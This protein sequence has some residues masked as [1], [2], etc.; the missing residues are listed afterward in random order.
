M[1][2]AVPARGRMSPTTED[3]GNVMN[4]NSALGSAFVTRNVLSSVALL[5]FSG[6][7]AAGAQG[8]VT[9]SANTD[10]FSIVGTLLVSANGKGK[11]DFT[12]IVHR[13]SVDGTTVAAVCQYKHFADVVISGPVATF[14]SV[15]SC[16]TLTSSGTRVPFTSDNTFGIVDNGEPGAGIDTIDVNL[17][18][19][20]GITIPGSLLVDGNFVVVP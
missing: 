13:D 16:F 1:R 4:R 3:R 15:G 12:V 8:L 19:G 7:Q 5:A 10:G 18:S 20:G 11:G 17:A 14:R 6:I 2:E 9:G